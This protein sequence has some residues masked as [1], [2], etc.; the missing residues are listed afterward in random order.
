MGEHREKFLE[1][2]G[3]DDFAEE[4]EYRA[5]GASTWSTMTARVIREAVPELRGEDRGSF[6]M[7]R[8]KV[9]FLAEAHATYGG[10]ASPAHAIEFKL[11][12]VRGGNPVEGWKGG[13]PA[14]RDGTW[15]IMAELD[16]R[17]ETG[18]KRR[19]RVS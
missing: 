12:K 5:A 17:V 11:A 14:G 10:I 3:D 9:R 1:I 16:D 7:Y 6:G 15:E 13:N 19:G 8:A 4:I 2:L 18:G